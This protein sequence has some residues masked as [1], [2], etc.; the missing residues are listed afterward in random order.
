MLRL[1]A[2]TVEGAREHGRFT[3]VCGGI[4]GDPQA[5]PILIGLG[6]DELSVSLPAIPTVKAQVRRLSHADCR[7]L[8]RRALNC[9]TGAEVRA[10]LP[11][12]EPLNL[13]SHGLLLE[14]L[15]LSP[16]DRQVHDAAGLG[17]AGRRHPA[18]RRQR[19]LLVAAAGRLASHG[20]SGNAIFANLPLLFAIGVAIG[21]TDNDGVAALAGTV[22]F[23]GLP[24]RDGRLR[25]AARHRN[26]DDHGHSHR[27]RPASSAA[28][29]SV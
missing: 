25:E 11:E 22:G 14:R 16:E 24:R 6:V 2:Q 27:S 4:A 7:E 26:G 5:V 28:S 15:L 9:S 17:A 20:A 3:G 29:S 10:L 21:L 12:T 8:A 23:V 13:Q 1:I 18:R 19:E